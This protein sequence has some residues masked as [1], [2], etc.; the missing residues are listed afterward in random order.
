MSEPNPVYTIATHADIEL[1]PEG[2]A[3]LQSAYRSIVSAGL[4][5]QRQ[6]GLPPERCAV[7][8]REERLARQLD[9]P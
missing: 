7:L 5:I 1:M 9:N 2:Y 8:T 4:T 6:L 3:E